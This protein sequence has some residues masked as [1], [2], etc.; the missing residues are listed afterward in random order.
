[1]EKKKYSYL[2]VC[3][4]IWGLF[5]VTM[6]EFSMFSMLTVMLTS[7]GSEVER[8]ALE[9]DHQHCAGLAEF[10]P[11]LYTLRRWEHLIFQAVG[12]RLWPLS[13]APP[14][15]PEGPS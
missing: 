2:F 1:M 11:F 12:P 7:C 4:G 14:L 8:E 10:G 6:S 9:S 13:P 15:L 5:D 3:G